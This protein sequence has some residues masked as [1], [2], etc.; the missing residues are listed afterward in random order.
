MMEVANLARLVSFISQIH[1]SSMLQQHLY[2]PTVA[3]V[4]CSGMT[5]CPRVCRYMLN[6]FYLLVEVICCAL[7]SSILTMSGSPYIHAYNRAVHTDK[8]HGVVFVYNKDTSNNKNNGTAFNLGVQVINQ[9]RDVKFRQMW[10]MVSVH[11][12]YIITHQ[13]LQHQRYRL[14]G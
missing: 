13:Q 12:Q 4:A 3:V 10:C 1:N 6:I 8:S 14:I 5:C 7:L 11:V 9:H 2:I